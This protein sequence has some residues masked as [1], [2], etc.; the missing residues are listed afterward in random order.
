MLTPEQQGLVLRFIRTLDAA[1]SGE[2]TFRDVV[3]TLDLDSDDRRGLQLYLDGLDDEG[4]I[5]RVRRGRYSIAGREAHVS[6]TLSRHRAG[7]GD[8]DA[9]RPGDHGE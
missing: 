7:Y 2:F 9:L 8:V 5:R 4:V 1:A 3:R 6:G